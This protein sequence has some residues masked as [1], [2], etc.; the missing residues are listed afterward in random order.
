MKSEQKASGPNRFGPLTEGAL[1][2]F[3]RDNQIDETG[4]YDESSQDAIRQLNE[5]VKR[6]SKGNVVLGLQMRLVALSYMTLAHVSSGNK[7]FGPVTEQALKVFQLQHGITP[8][9]VLTDETYRALL[10]SAPTPPSIIPSTDSTKVDTVLPAEGRG[11]TTYRREQG[12][13]DQYG[14]ASTIRAIMEIAE[15]WSIKHATPRLQFGDISRRGGGHFSPHKA[16]QNGLEAD[17]RPI[18]NNGREEATNISAMNYSHVLTKEFVQLVKSKFPNAK[19][20]FN[21]TQLIN[22]GLTSPLAGHSDHLHIRFPG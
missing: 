12:G 17:A 6:N 5:G 8:S 2:R 18:T 4:V 15:A 7:N 14:R 20:F 16:H 11:F 21:D 1:K 22:L 13:A 3:Q 9:G 10:T 19:I